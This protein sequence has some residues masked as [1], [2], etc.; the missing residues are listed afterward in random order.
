MSIQF[1]NPTY[2]KAAKE[3]KKKKKTANNVIIQSNIDDII[4]IWSYICV[5]ISITCLDSSNRQRNGFFHDGHVDVVPNIWFGRELSNSFSNFHVFRKKRTKHSVS[6]FPLLVV[7]KA[8]EKLWAGTNPCN[9]TP[10][11]DWASLC[12][13]LLEWSS[14]GF[15]CSLNQCKRRAKRSL[16]NSQ[17]LSYN[18]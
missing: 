17:R 10:S 11:Y 2:K 7:C 3:E 5:Q 6:V 14:Q 1:P 18:Y 13:N 12:W 9:W 16:R 4:S 8:Y 15:Q